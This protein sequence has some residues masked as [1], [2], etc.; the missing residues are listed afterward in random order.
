MFIFQL[1]FVSEVFLMDLVLLSLE[2]DLWFK[3]N[4]SRE[5]FRPVLNLTV[6]PTQTLILTGGQFS[7]GALLQTPVSLNGNV[8]DFS[9]D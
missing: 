9:V 5:N 1:S 4:F 8:Y 7:S 2:K 6:T 3:D